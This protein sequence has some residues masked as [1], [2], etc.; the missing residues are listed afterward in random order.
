MRYK[1]CQP[2]SRLRFRM[3]FYAQRGR[4]QGMHF[5]AADPSKCGVIL[6]L[7]KWTIETK[8]EMGINSYFYSISQFQ[9]AFSLP[10]AEDYGKKRKGHQN[11]WHL[12]ARGNFLKCKDSLLPLLLQGKVWLGFSAVLGGRYGTDR[13]ELSA[14]QGPIYISWFPSD[15]E[16]HWA[17]LAPPTLHPLTPRHMSKSS[18]DQQHCPDQPRKAHPQVTLTHV[19]KAS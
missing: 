16:I 13:A 7:V 9:K 3:E 10:E 1:F 4:G 14:Q 5:A 18:Q 15:P 17:S 2:D 19:S 12:T 6:E 11:S 8:E